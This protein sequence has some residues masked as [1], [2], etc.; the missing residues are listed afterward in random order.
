MQMQMLLWK[1]HSNRFSGS[2]GVKK[3]YNIIT[4]PYCHPVA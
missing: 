3:S 1:S 2:M 4:T